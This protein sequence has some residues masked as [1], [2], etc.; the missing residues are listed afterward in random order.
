M[1][2]HFWGVRGSIAT[3]LTNE[4]VQAKI[5]AAVQRITAEDIV[6]QDAR[7]RFMAS[8]PK[9]L[10]GTM[11]GNTA[12]LEIET[13]NGEHL[14]FDSG[15]GI[16]ALGRYLQEQPGYAD[17]PHTYHLFFTHF[18]WDHLQ[19]LPFFAPSYDPRNTI[20]VYSVEPKVKNILEEQMV[21]PYFPVT[22]FGKG[23]FAAK[24]EFRCIEPSE[25]F[26]FIGDTRIG[27]HR[28][29][30]PGGCV[31]YSISEA[32]KKVIFSTDTEICAQDFEKNE[33]NTAFYRDV[34]LFIIDAQYTMTESIEK[35]GWGHS[36]FSF[37]I[38]FAISWN[39]K[40]MALFHHEP[41]YN[42]RKILSIQTNAQHY[43]R[44]M[45]EKNPLEIFSA[46]EGTDIYL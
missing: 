36:S 21:W 34:D 19:G 17:G 13:G 41:T 26:V 39:M 1:R 22:M 44:H 40:R 24:F 18:H 20:I 37:A 42:D 43:C 12:C 46:M 10:F 32:G 2:I 27:W 28:V 7:E 33:K 38:D 14:I 8:L 11:G 15:T 3:P 5:S 35:M 45:Y 30:H 16:R 29:R 6:D 31:A 23:G 9:W 4:Q 25:P